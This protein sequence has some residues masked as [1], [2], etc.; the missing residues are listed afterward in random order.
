MERNYTLFYINN[1]LRAAFKL[2]LTQKEYERMT[3]VGKYMHLASQT[4]FLVPTCCAIVPIGLK[5]IIINENK[6]ISFHSRNTIIYVI[7][8]FPYILDAGDKKFLLGK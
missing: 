8:Q 4:F 1:F 3:E 7:R 6:S 2:P 5:L